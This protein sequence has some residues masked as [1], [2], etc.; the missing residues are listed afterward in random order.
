MVKQNEV[1]MLT[2]EII[3]PEA[4]GHASEVV[5]KY[6]YKKYLEMKSIDLELE[7]NK[8][9]SIKTKANSKG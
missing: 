2:V 6:F 8:D 9:K 1:G 7:T 4:L 5:T 3:N